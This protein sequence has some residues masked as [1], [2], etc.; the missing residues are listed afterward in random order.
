MPPNRKGAFDAV[1]TLATLQVSQFVD[2][3]KFQPLT[4]APA[5]VESKESDDGAQ[6]RQ[7][8]DPAKQAII[9]RILLE[10]RL[11]EQFSAD[12]IIRACQQQDVEEEKTDLHREA[13]ES[14][15][16][17]AMTTPGDLSN[18]V[19]SKR[20]DASYWDWPTKTHR[21]DKDDVI[22]T[23]LEQE[24]IRQLFS[25]DH[26]VLKIKEEAAALQKKES[27]LPQN[28]TYWSWDAKVDPNDDDGQMD[29]DK[30]IQKILEAEVLRQQFSMVTLEKNL[31]PE[32]KEQ[33]VSSADLQNDEYWAGF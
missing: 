3:A 14:D 33:E 11:R 29:K 6:P 30:I 19:R 8:E 21:E 27:P 17:W 18:D 5:Q 32:R 25:A 26:V 13:T 23:I 31:M 7:Y 22:Q 10:E 16:Y 20:T 15:D 2:R 24:R 9:D 1:D 28:D 4:A 12:H